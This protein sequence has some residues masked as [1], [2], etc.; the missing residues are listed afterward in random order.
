V[1]NTSNYSDT[2]IVLIN[3]SW[4]AV[5]EPVWIDPLP[6]HTSTTL[7]VVVSIPIDAELGSSSVAI[8]AVTSLTDDRKQAVASLTTYVEWGWLYLPLVQK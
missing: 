6:P 5:A 3:S 8:V 4:I 2:F 7:Q 1:T